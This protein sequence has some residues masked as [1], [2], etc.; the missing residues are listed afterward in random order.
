VA[1]R[2]AFTP[3]VTLPSRA[4]GERFSSVILTMA[5]AALLIAGRADPTLTDRV[6]SQTTDFVAP[7]LIMIQQP[8]ATARD[9]VSRTQG[10]LDLAAENAR[11]REENGR[12][13]AWEATALSLEA[14]SQVLRGMVNLG[15][16]APPI[17]RTEPI[18]A[19]P[20]GFYVRSVLIGGGAHDGLGKGQAAMAGAGLAGRIT[21]IGAWSA[22]VLLITDLNSRIPVILEGT[23][24][25][26][27]LAGDNS[28]S[29]Y[30]MY[31][32]KA[33]AISPGDRL[34][35]AGHDG[36]FPTGLPVGR[37][38]S[39]ENGEIRVEPIADLDR[40]EYL[41][42]VDSIAQSALT[43]EIAPAEGRGFFGT[44]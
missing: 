21:E 4:F 14:Q 26:A 18:I 7:L 5:A 27:I 40:L 11:L 37:V 17:L 38:S 31:L 19:E 22:R 15:P 34:V 10:M 3:T 32:P 9:A 2:T 36:V 1:Q 16:A 6:R 25:H 29:P 43:P 33:A 30:L 24:T 28:R 39:I 23:R 8:L 20:G 13:K 41:G 44:P 35:T 12:L 42:L